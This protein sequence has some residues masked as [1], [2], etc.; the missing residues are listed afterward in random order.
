MNNPNSTPR[1][2]RPIFLGILLLL[3]SPWANSILAQNQICI[4]YANRPD[5]EVAFL[6]DF[7]IGQQMN[8][9]VVIFHASDSSAWE[10]LKSDFNINTQQSSL[11]AHKTL[12]MTLRN[13][14][15]PQKGFQEPLMS[16]CFLKGVESD[17]TLCLYYFRSDAQYRYLVGQALS[18]YKDNLK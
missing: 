16:N 9:D 6:A 5:I 1:P 18:N 4:Q 7:P 17:M 13:R 14:E 2:F 12:F 3:V 11:P 15:N 10:N 8:A